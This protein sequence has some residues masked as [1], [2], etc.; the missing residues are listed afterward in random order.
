MN[1]AYADLP[2]VVSAL[3]ALLVLAGASLSLL[4]AW[5]LVRLPSFYDRVHA[6]TLGA[7]LGMA[8]VLAASWLLAG[9]AQD[10]WMPRELLIAVFLTITTP[11][12][13]LLLARAAAYRD[14]TEREPSDNK[15]VPDQEEPE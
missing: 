12:T 9:T 1:S 4:G 6:P 11:I 8:L 5:G 7:T 2:A 14:R 3:V 15:S 13:L 10:R